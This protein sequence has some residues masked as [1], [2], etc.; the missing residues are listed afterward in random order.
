IHVSWTT[1]KREQ[2][3]YRFIKLRADREPVDG[4]SRNEY[5]AARFQT[6]DDFFNHVH[7]EKSCES[8]LKLVKKYIRLIIERLHL[9]G[10]SRT[11]PP[12]LFAQPQQNSRI[13]ILNPQID[14]ICQQPRQSMP[15]PPRYRHPATEPITDPG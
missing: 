10:R 1:L 11:A 6:L 13:R 4:I 14:L 2:P 12:S 7:P 5:Y 9:H 8:C 15:N 3:I